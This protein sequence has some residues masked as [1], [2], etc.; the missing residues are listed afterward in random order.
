MK[1]NVSFPGL[2][3]LVEDMGASPVQWKSDPR[4]VSSVNKSKS[5]GTEFDVSSLIDKPPSRQTS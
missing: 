5:N 3:K 4:H 2:E 1:L